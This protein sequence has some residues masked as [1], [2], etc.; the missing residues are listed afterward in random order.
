MFLKRFKLFKLFGYQVHAD[1]SWFIVAFLVVWTLAVALF[2]S[3]FPELSLG[4][5]VVMGVVGALG[6]FMSIVLHEYCHAWTAQ[7]FGLP[8]KGITLFIFG[9]VAEMDD[10]PPS[11]K[12]EFWMALAGPLA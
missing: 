12:A 7:R 5:Y 2:P 10:E 9:G 8:M 6:F 3:Q 1:V 4:T 11:P